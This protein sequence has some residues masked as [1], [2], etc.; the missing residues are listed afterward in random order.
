[1]ST[2]SGILANV[3]VGPKWAQCHRSVEN[4]WGRSKS[5]TWHW[6]R[7]QVRWGWVGNSMTDLYNTV[8][9]TYNVSR[10][11]ASP[12]TVS[13]WQLWLRDSV[14]FECFRNIV[15]FQVI[16]RV[17]SDHAQARKRSDQVKKVEIDVTRMVG[18]VAKKVDVMDRARTKYLSSTTKPVAVKGTGEAIKAA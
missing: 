8:Y 4:V 12:W 10:M 6:K 15:S 9:T 2:L 18:I 7:R 1:M 16:R 3:T 11:R 17:S 13:Q 14:P 5:G